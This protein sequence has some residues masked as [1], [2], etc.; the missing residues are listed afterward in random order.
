ME[1]RTQS[2][3][4]R[5]SPERRAEVEERVETLLSELT[6][7]QKVGQLNQLNADFSTGTAVGDMDVERGILDGDIG[8]VLNFTDLEEARRF[9]ELAV[10]ES[11]H[12]IPLVLALDVIHGHRTIFPIPLGEAA[13]WNPEM[14]EL[15]ARVAATEAA[16][17]GVQWTFAPS[18]DVSRDAR[19]GRVMEAAGEDPYLA[20]EFSK[21]RVRGFQG[22]DLAADDTILACAKHFVG[23]GAV[24]AG[25]EYNTVDV[26]ETALREVHLP[27]FEACLE[28]GVGS[29]MN[30]F[31][32]HERIPASSNETLVAGLLRDELDFEGLVVSD[33]DSFGELVEH[34]VAG[35]LRDAARACIEAGS[36]VDMVS[37]AY[38]T[39]LVELVEDGVVEESLVDRAVRRLL[40][41]KAVLGLFEDPYR[42]FDEERRSRRTLTDDHREAAREVAGESQVLLKNEDDLLPLNDGGDVALVGGLAD[43]ATDMLG[44]WHAVGDPAD[45]TTLKTTLTDRVENLTYAEGCDRDGSVGDEQLEA[46]VKAVAAADVAVVAVGERYDQ[47][48][49]AASRAHLDLP[50]DQ[51][52]LLEALVGTGTPVAAVLFNG[53]PLAIDWEAEHVPAILEAWFPGVEAGPAI[54]DVLLGEHDPSGRLPMS[55]PVTEGQIPVYYNRLRTG[56]PAEDADADLT[57]PPANPGEK[58]TSRYLDVPNDPLYAFGHGESYTAFAYTGVTLGA[59][60]I[61]AGESL[62]VDVTVENVGDRAGTEVVQVYLRDVVGSRARP[63]RELV[64]FENVDLDAGESATV[65]FELT[66]ADLEFWTADEAYAAEPGEFEVQVGHAADDVTAVETFELVE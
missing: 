56:R 60:A 7:E 8:S 2:L 58:Y 11:D 51:R 64:R 36:D 62:A 16:A 15:S 27:P 47:S 34:G 3:L 5:V 13:S 4:D 28:A 45:V 38:A 10:E 22:D 19:W 57:R 32:L 17:S 55:F 41:V 1:T 35:D 40:T 48:G 14:A 6:L 12:G 65:S 66:T 24:E 46:A 42:Y 53:R 30:A 50:G 63:V 52:A 33:W 61:T 49:E 43:S 9:Q 59:A 29:V 26:S 21:A 44:A 37:G 39:E 25:R 23:Y 31:N 54:V 20:G 18:V